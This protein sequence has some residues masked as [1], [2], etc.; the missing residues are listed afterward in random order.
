MLPVFVS[1]CIEDMNKYGAEMMPLRRHALFLRAYHTAA[2][3]RHF[4][5]FIQYVMIQEPWRHL[6]PLMLTR[7]S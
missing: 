2:E 6:T 7:R 4:V 1:I 3:R 5:P